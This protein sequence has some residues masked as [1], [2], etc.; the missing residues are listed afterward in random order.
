MS[1][2]NVTEIP[3]A[4]LHQVV[5]RGQAP[6]EGIEIDFK[7]KKQKIS[8]DALSMK[9]SVRTADW[10]C[11]FPATRFYRITFQPLGPQGCQ[12]L[13]ELE[14]RCEFHRASPGGLMEEVSFEQFVVESVDRA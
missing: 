9:C 4:N 1:N 6:P 7:Q 14:A 10:E 13:V 5:L 8:L 11:P 3:V 12:T 2:N